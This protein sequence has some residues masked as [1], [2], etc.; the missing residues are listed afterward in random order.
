VESLSL[1]NIKKIKSKFVLYNKFICLNLDDTFQVRKGF[2]DIKYDIICLNS[3]GFLFVSKVMQQSS[4][5]LRKISS[6]FKQ[7]FS[8]KTGSIP[9]LR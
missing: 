5:Y 1:Y 6:T 3:R 4:P 2:S 9:V 7:R 8:E